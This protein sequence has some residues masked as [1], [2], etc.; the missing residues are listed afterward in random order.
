[1][2]YTIQYWQWQYRLK[3]NLWLVPRLTQQAW[4]AVLLT[5]SYRE[6]KTRRPR[7]VLLYCCRC[8]LPSDRVNPAESLN[9]VEGALQLL[10]NRY[11]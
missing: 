6:N 8:M 5:A 10:I 3:A 1:M 4:P 2:P 9:R 11:S 7:R